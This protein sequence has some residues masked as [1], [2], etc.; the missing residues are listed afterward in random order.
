LTAN[1]VGVIIYTYRYKGVSMSEEVKL[2][3]TQGDEGQWLVWF[4][5][6]LGGKHVLEEFTSESEALAFWQEQMDSADFGEE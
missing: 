2:Y 4:P 5:H 1:A 6:P 3:C